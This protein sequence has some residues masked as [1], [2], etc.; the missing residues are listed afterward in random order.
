MVGISLFTK[1]QTRD[2]NYETKET[3][4]DDFIILEEADT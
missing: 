2:N 3:P 4:T 1:I